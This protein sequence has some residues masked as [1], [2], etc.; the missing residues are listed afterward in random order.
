MKPR[1]LVIALF[2]LVLGLAA[3]ACGSSPTSPTYSAVAVSGTVP[4]VGSSSQFVATAVTS[5]GTTSD[6]STTAT[7]TSSNTSVATVS[8]TGLVTAVG[9]GATTIS[10]TYSGLSGL[11]AITVP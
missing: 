8:A 6:V 11:D 7:W 4:D 9:S 2:A 3:A 10:A 1:S 5:T